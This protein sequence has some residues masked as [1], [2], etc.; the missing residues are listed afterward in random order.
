MKK[1]II[2]SVILIILIV[3]VAVPAYAK[4]EKL[5][6]P[7]GIAL[8]YVEFQQIKIS[9][10][11]VEGAEGYKVLRKEKSAKKWTSLGETT[12]TSFVDKKATNGKTFYYTVRAYDVSGD[13][14]V[15][16]EYNTTGKKKLSKLPAPKL[17]STKY[18]D[19]KTIKL[20]WEESV[21]ADGYY[22]Y[23]KKTSD[24]SWKKIASTTKSYYTD[25]KA[26]DGT[27]YYYTARPYAET[28][29]GKVLG[30]YDTD[31]LK[32]YSKMVA[33]KLVSAKCTAPKSITLNWKEVAGADG[34]RV[35][36]KKQGEESWNK[37]KDVTSLK[38]TDKTAAL[39]VTYVY[40]VAPYAKDGSKKILGRKDNDGI[41][42]TS[43]VP[44]PQPVSANPYGFRRVKISWKAVSGA[45]GYYVFRKEKS[46]TEWT[47]LGLTSSTAF[48]DKTAI[49]NTEYQYCIKAYV[50]LSKGKALSKV[51]KVLTAKAVFPAPKNLAAEN[52]AYNKIRIKWDEVSGAN[53]YRVYRKG[54]ESDKWEHI[55]NT[56]TTDFTDTVSC[57]STY[58][59]TVRGYAAADGETILSGYDKKGISIKACPAEPVL[60]TTGGVKE[61]TLNW[62]AEK[63][64]DGFNIYRKV[65]G[66][67]WKA[68]GST[69]KLT[70]RD[71]TAQP[72]VKYYY[73]VRAYKMCGKTKVLNVCTNVVKGM[74]ISHVHFHQGD[75]AWGFSRSLEKN[76]C[77]LSCMSMMLK[78]LGENANPKLVYAANGKDAGMEFDKALAHYDRK[79]VCALSESSKYLSSYDAK[80]GWTYV[81]NPEQIATKAIREALKRNPEGVMCYFVRGNDMHG[82]VA[83]GCDANNIYYSDPGRVYE[84]GYNVTFNNTWVKKGHNMGYKHLKL[85]QAI[86]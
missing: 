32:R 65:S 10:D 81:K 2:F 3:L 8:K 71:D 27:T 22:V 52:A 26:S 35:Y 28:K 16:G 69:T 77:V 53:G 68:L 5:P 18:T 62:T 39:G 15:Y 64:V 34:Y 56:K 84:R 7:S 42:Q 78:N 36:R 85:I 79:N 45:D 29:S 11:A 72:G 38:Y 17:V 50:T 13:S 63:G 83:I 24:K 40:T 19:F 61:I 82:I 48:Y 43:E 1:R 21:G 74:C 54:S 14:K 76:A 46:S 47:T 86:D 73:A 59:Y 37:L 75:D 44:P 80:W 58:F 60:K 4:G 55:G 57:G 49:E 33:P 20:D 70:Y 67:E 41:K 23:R 30:K 12:K 9:W 6:A 25:K 51:Q 66:G 31:G